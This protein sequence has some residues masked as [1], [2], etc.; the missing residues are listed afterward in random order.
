[1]SYAVASRS[2]VIAAVLCVTLAP[3]AAASPGSPL[4]PG[5][6]DMLLLSE[7]EVSSIIGLPMH[8]QGDSAHAP[9]TA[10]TLRERNECKVLTYND[11]DLWSGDFTAFRVIAQQDQPDP[12]FT[13]WQ[14][15]ATYPDSQTATRVFRHSFNAALGKRC[16]AGVVPD[17]LDEHAQWRVAKLTVSASAASWSIAL[18]RDRQEITW[19]CADEVR[20]KR[21]VMYQDAECQFGNGIS[22]ARQMADMTARRISN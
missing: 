5:K 22:L 13:A 15:V 21:N 9:A 2:A 8:Q 12:E 11:V 17:A 14:G 19:R 4:G 10:V 20:M 3:A 18:L 7:D 1:M 6:I 16:G